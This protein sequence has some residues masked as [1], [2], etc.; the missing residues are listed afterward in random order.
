MAQRLQDVL[1]GPCKVLQ[2]LI[3]YRVI[4]RFVFSLLQTALPKLVFDY[5]LVSVTV[6]RE[7][8]AVIVR[9]QRAIALRP[10]VN[11]VSLASSLIGLPL[12]ERH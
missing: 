9:D 12:K 6:D 4:L 5:R 3:A 8:P 11:D 7:F 10:V 1:Y 2:L